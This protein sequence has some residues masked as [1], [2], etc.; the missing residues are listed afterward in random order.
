MPASHYYAH[1]V[2]ASSLASSVLSVQNV[3]ET[4]LSD[5]IAQ[6]EFEGEKLA[7]HNFEGESSLEATTTLKNDSPALIAELIKQ[8]FPKDPIMLRVADCESIGLRHYV[9]GEV[10]RGEQVKEDI[11]LFQINETY[12]LEKAQAKELDIYELEGNI[13]MA[14]VILKEQGLNAWIHS[15][16]CWLKNI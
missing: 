12:W 1:T 7:H 15:R 8:E 16:N 4:V 3:P 11:G 6:D 13:K 14:G 5:K 9:N 2:Y 10:L